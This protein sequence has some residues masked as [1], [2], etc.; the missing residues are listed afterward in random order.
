MKRR[1]LLLFLL[2]SFFVPL[3][4]LGQQLTVYDVTSTN[5][6]IP[7]YMFYFDDFTRSQFVI[8][9]ADLEI[10]NGSAITSIK[11]YTTNSNVPYTTVSMADVYLKEVDYTTINAFEPKT[12]IVY[13]GTLVVV[14]ENGGGSLTIELAT[15][16]TYGGGN[17]LVGIENTTDAGYKNISFYG[18]SVTGASVGDYNSSSLDN[19]TPTQRDFIPKTTFTYEPVSTDCDMPA[20]LVVSNITAD[21]A[22]VTW[23]GEGSQWNL[24]YKASTDSEFTVVN[25]LTN[26]SYTL[27][28]L[29]ET[30]TYSVGVQTVC[31]GSTSFFRSAAFTTVAGIPL[32]EE[33]G[34]SIPTGWVMYKGLLST[35]ADGTAL[36][37]AGSGWSFGTGNSVFDNH[38]RVNI[39]GTS[40]QNWLLM[41]TLMME[42]NVQLTFDLALTVYSSGSNASP[43]PGNQADDKFAVLITTDGGSTWTILRQWDNA[44]SEYVYDNIPNTGT[45]VAIDLSSYAGQSIGIAFYGES[46]V[47]GGDN[48]LHIDNVSVGYFFACPAPDVVVNNITHTSAVVA[49]TGVGNSY[50]VSYRELSQNEYNDVNL[51]EEIL[52]SEW[53]LVATTADTN[54]IIPNLSADTYYEVKVQ[55]TCDNIQSEESLVTFRTLSENQKIFVTEGEWDNAANWSGDIPNIDNEVIVRANAT[56]PSGCVA[57]ANNITFEGTPTPTLTISDGGQLKTNSN[58]TATVKKNITGYGVENIATNNGYYL[59]AAPTIPSTSAS[60]A[61]LITTT[62]DNEPTYDLY[63]W[64]RTATDEEW[65]NTKI[66]GYYYLYNGN[67]YLYANQ[68]DLEMSITGTILRSDEPVTMTAYHDTV[69]GGWNLFGNPFP[70]NAYVY[71]PDG[72]LIDVMFYDTNGE[73]VTL[74]GGPVAP[75]QGFFVKVTETTTITIKNA[76]EYIDLGLPSGLLWASCNVGASTPDG[77]GDYFAWGETQPKE[78]YNWSTYQYCDGNR[79][80]MTKYCGNSNYGNG[81]FTDSLTTLLPED[82]AATANMGAGWRMPTSIEWAELYNNTTSTWTTQNGVYGR[83]F[84]APN[85]S[86]LFLPNAGYRYD[87]DLLDMGSFGYY[88]SSS[89]NTADPDCARHFD[90]N[91]DYYGVDY[92]GRRYGYAVRAVR[93]SALSISFTATTEHQ[94]GRTSLDPNNGQVNWTTGDQMVIGNVTG[95]TS[96]F[97]LQSGEGTTEGVFGASNGFETVG[98]FI[99][100]Y[101]L[102]AV[103]ENDKV[104]FNLPSTQVIAETETFANGAN[105]MVARSDDNNLSFKNL[106][107]GLGIRLKGLGAHVTAIRITSMDTTEKLWG[108]YEVNNCAA[109]EP[110]LTVASGNQGTNV[111][112]LT[113]DV[114]LTTEAKTF[115]VMLP[116]GT[117]A[118]GFTVEVFD[119]EEVL[120]TAETTSDVFSVERNLLKFFNEILIDLEFDGNVEIPSNLNN[121]DIVVTNL[122][123]DAIPDENG[124][125][126][127]GY[128]TTLTMKNA[129]NNEVIYM[130]IPSVNNDMAKEEGQPQNYDLNAK[131]T[132]LYYALTMIPFGLCQTEDATFNSIKEVLYDLDC[133]QALENAIEQSVI[134]NGY[135]RAED[136]GAE[137]NAVWNYLEAELLAPFLEMQS[138]NSGDNLGHIVL[139]KDGT[140]RL[141]QPQIQPNNGRYRGIRLDIESASFNESSNTW[142]LNLTG[143]S[144]N[145]VFIGMK[146]GTNVDGQVQP[147]DGRT[148]YFLPPMNVGKFMGTFTSLGGLKDYF[149]D[150]WRLFTEDDF[151][152]DDMTWDK[153][154]LQNISFELGPNENALC[155]YSPKDDQATAVVNCVYSIMQVVGMGL[156]AILTSRGNSEFFTS[157]FSN[158]ELC[159]TIAG[160]V[161]H[162]ENFTTAT[163]DLL[164]WAVDLF[165]TEAFR[166]FINPKYNADKILDKLASSS[167]RAAVEYVGNGLGTLASW[168]L[169]DSFPFT[170]EAE[171]NSILPTVSTPSSEVLSPTQAT[172]VAELESM[173]T[174]S[175]TEVGV[176]YRTTILPSV[177]DYCVS[178]SSIQTSGSYQCQLNDL[179]PNTTY[180][181]RA[182][183]KC[184]LDIVVY[185]NQVSFTTESFTTHEYVDLGLPS[186]LLWATCNVGADNPEDYGDYFAWGETTPKDTYTWENYQYCNG[187]DNTLTKYCNKSNYGYN[188][189]TDDLT[190]LLPEDDAAT[191]NWGTDWRMPTD[192][193]WVELFSNT[194]HVLTTQNGVNGGLF[195]GTNGNTL[196]LPI[197]GYRD[198]NNLYNADAEYGDYWSN[199]LSM[200]HPFGA[201]SYQFYFEWDSYETSSSPRYLGRPVRAVRSWSTSFIINATANP[202]N[203]GTVTGGGTYNQGQSCTLTAAANSGYTFTNW[204]E[205]GNVVS[206]EASYTFTVNSD[207]NLVAN[208]TFNGGGGGD[209]HAYVDLG[210]PSGLLWAT[211]NVGAS[212]P[213][214][215]GDYF[216]WGETLPKDYYNW[217]TYQYCNGSDHTL[218]KYCSISNYGNNGFTDNLTT[219]L[220]EDDAATANWGSDWRMPTEE[221][222]QELYQNTTHTWTTQNGVIG[223]LFTASNGN[224]LFL[225]AVSYRYEGGLNVS[226]SGGFYWSSSLTTICPYDAWYLCFASDQCGMHNGYCRYYGLSVRAVRFGSSSFIINAT[227]NPANGGTVTGGGTYN[228]GQS[229]TV[230][231]TANS[232]YTFTNWTEN[233][234][235]VSTESSYTFPVNG[236][237]DLVAN[238]TFYGGGGDDLA[239]VD[240]GLPS[241][242]LWATCNVGANAPEEYGDYFAWGETQPKRVYNFYTY[243]YYEDGSNLTKYTGSDGL[244]TLLPED[245]AATANWGNGWRMPTKEEWEELYNNTTVTWTQQNGVNG[246][247]FT[248]PDGNSLFLPA[249]SYRWQEGLSS[250]GRE[251]YYWSSSLRTDYPDLVWAFV[252]DSGS[253]GMYDASRVDGH[254]VRAVRSWSTSISFIINAT[255]NLVEGGMVSGGGTYQ[256]GTNCT[257]TAMANEGYSFISWTENGIVISTETTYSFTVSH[258]R[259][260]VANF[261]VSGATTHEY[262]DLGLPS[263]LLWATCNVGADTPEDYGDYFAWGETQPK[264]TYYWSTYMYA[265]DGTSILDMQLTKYCNKSNYGYNGFTDN[266]TTLLPEDDAATANWGNGWRMPTQAEMQELFDNTTVTWT[267]QNGVYGK[268]F[269]A[270]N[271]N[272]L[273]LPAAGHRYGSSLDDAGGDGYYW[274]SSLNTDYPSY[275]RDFYFRSDSFSM[276]GSSRYY[277]QS[278]RPV[279]SATQN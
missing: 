37:P 118:S 184:P 250:V 98:P 231:A 13:Q 181:A 165:S 78:V 103:I 26:M 151:W 158:Q 249:A 217:S 253:Y 259:N 5:N 61:G 266:L 89:L 177:N 7:A 42:N 74:N 183:A 269:T 110:S 185:G 189:F 153:A 276:I 84:T 65:Q 256:D 46:T 247:L 211:C 279:H 121:M 210:L 93:S 142:T 271:G 147:T 64:D 143:Y 113:C 137:L 126:F 1:F 172:V 224:S 91:S 41:P 194:T 225:P 99:A 119:G 135:L 104:T 116:P 28:G 262:V 243:Q 57:E 190:T 6:V 212:S 254:S 214:D 68:N 241:G 83:L 215:C 17:L 52:D 226:T 122:G 127:I 228:H 162:P 270:D 264:D 131:E 136:I 261:V 229:C 199:L 244:T 129:T 50:I 76:L 203:G 274:S 195:I 81:G 23:E 53:Q 180:Y 114:N 59:I 240:L 227:V 178:Y 188:G 117:L 21:G 82:D 27:S 273:F 67:G 79:Y 268:L 3:T 170:V 255:A 239:Y 30:T 134:Q 44:G 96:V 263:G 20:S 234:N 223:R 69:A 106:C 125:F 208:F 140:T 157:L 24:R 278:V 191:V 275:A 75:M 145:G 49:W 12:N 18:T 9:A 138:S 187:S 56:V 205:N 221:E 257:L 102:D 123:E 63:S 31:T 159:A 152:F 8:P 51:D 45:T 25:G 168:D 101:P 107:G 144:D 192:E 209:D 164:I 38:A 201:W 196:F 132:A 237:R 87:G 34:T 267:Q 232:G 242:L 115:F 22:T 198:G 120:T 163:N 218:T 14:S 277:G 202:A 80:S 71:R 39:Y 167:S 100:A 161:G 10:M 149:V 128:S 15:P 66:F 154:K 72:T 133:V 155:M 156:D 43:T 186:G 139:K 124:D 171:Y 97:T 90:F 235:V 32:V 58:I 40:C 95:E 86:S 112:T 238:F 220:P 176:C 222:W 35:I 88:W 174:L 166:K 245:D 272:S 265:N 33:F 11:F 197:A 148:P 206:T 219:L 175:I 213:E 146:K 92:N 248:V 54:V 2:A 200:L 111:I 258:N 236:D 179:Q 207:R 55:G 94:G 141:E 216:G 47:S 48:N 62:A 169:F 252:F 246:R 182:Y 105:P 19:V 29:D 77:C 230:T 109:D 233:G 204:T 173:G 36:T 251:G 108:T 193:E 16:Y 60:D 70:C 73:M 4:A 150:T 260:L 85:G 160:L 130:S